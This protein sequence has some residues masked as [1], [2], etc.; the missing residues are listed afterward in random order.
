MPS[1]SSKPFEHLPVVVRAN[2]FA[3]TLAHPS[4]KVGIFQSRD[5]LGGVRKH[6]AQARECRI[7][8]LER[9][10]RQPRMLVATTGKPIAA[11]SMSPEARLHDV[12]GS[13]QGIHYG[14]A[15][16]SVVTPAEEMH[17]ATPLQT[18]PCLSIASFWSDSSGPTTTNFRLGKR[19]TS[20]SA[21]SNN[22]R[23]SSS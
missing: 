8:R 2:V 17:D 3:S 22:S 20:I 23:N 11:A 9:S 12:R 1:E 19:G 21:A 5:G 4:T 7:S 13:S 14:V 10:S 16:A 18:R 6:Y 15:T